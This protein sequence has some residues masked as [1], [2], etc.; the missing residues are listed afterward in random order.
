MSRTAPRRGWRSSGS[1]SGR[2]GRSRPHGGS[3]RRMRGTA[4]T[5]IPKGTDPRSRGDAGATA[6]PA[7]TESLTAGSAARGRQA[8]RGLAELAVANEHLGHGVL[9]LDPR[10]EVQFQGDGAREPV[11]GD[12]LQEPA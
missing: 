6:G 2:T 8:E 12:Q 9:V 11:P 4:G 5:P 10:P 3:G 1:R 7:S